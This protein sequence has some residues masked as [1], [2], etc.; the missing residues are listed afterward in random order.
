MFVATIN[1]TFKS[2]LFAIVGAEYVLGW[3]PIGTHEWEK[4]VRPDDLMLSLK[5]Y[6]LKLDKLDGMS[7]NLLENE[8]SVSMD[9]SVNYIAKFIKN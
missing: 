5:K 7:F 6:S 8:W 4:F 9:K 1:K 3:L 2:Y